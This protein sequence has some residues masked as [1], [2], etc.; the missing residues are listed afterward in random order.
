APAPA[1][2]P[3][4]PPQPAGVSGGRRRRS[5]AV[6]LGHREPRGRPGISSL[7]PS[8]AASLT[9]VASGISYACRRCGGRHR[10]LPM[11]YGT[12]A[13]AYRDPSLAGDKTSTLGQERCVIKNEHF[14]VRGRLVIP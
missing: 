2:P 13:P 9:R 10:E 5:C 4:R 12:D 6:Q 14:F 3:A 1:Q 11:S 7:V 8:A